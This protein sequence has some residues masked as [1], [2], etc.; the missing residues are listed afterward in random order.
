MPTEERAEG[1][2]LERALDE[3]YAGP[4]EDFVVRRKELA[5]GL[6]DAGARESAK[7]LQKARKPTA[8]SWALNQ[9]A[10][11]DAEVL[12]SFFAE[13]AALQR[14]HSEALATKSNGHSRSS[15][16]RAAQRAQRRAADDVVARALLALERGGGKASATNE[17]TLRDNL[18][19]AAFGP[20]EARTALE[21]GRLVKELES[22]SGLT[23]LGAL[24][25][26]MPPSTRAPPKDTAPPKGTAPPK[27]PAREL[28]QEREVQLRE[29]EARHAARERAE[30]R[31]AARQRY[32]DACRVHDEA[33][34][35]LA[36]ADEEAGQLE[37]RAAQ[38]LR[39]AE[40]ARS[41]AEALRARVESASERITTTREAWR[42]L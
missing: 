6:R 8:L 39:E 5:K 7:Q 38:A 36:E 13:S 29:E 31:A 40:R 10:H 9:V 3:L 18:H 20:E 4:L 1:D 19:A 12:A 28:Q 21:S 15:S 41:R 34:R 33:K 42:S 23:A 32:D 16:L 25:F 17:R 35:A 2:A 11:H 14:A 24:P 27:A 22:A 26:E 30:E 37:R